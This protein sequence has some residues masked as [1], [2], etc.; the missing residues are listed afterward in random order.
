MDDYKRAHAAVAALDA[1]DFA[2]HALHFHVDT[3]SPRWASRDEQAL[4]RHLS[5]A[6]RLLGES[7][8]G[9]L[10]RDVER[11]GD[12]LGRRVAG[13]VLTELAAIN[14]AWAVFD[15]V[16][17]RAKRDLRL[18]PV[19]AL[20]EPP[21]E[22]TAT[23]QGISDELIQHIKRQPDVLY[24]LNPRRFEE[25]IAH[26]LDNYGWQVRMTPRTRDGGYDIFAISKDRSG[27]ECSWIIE[28]KK[29]AKDRKVG[30]ELARRLYF[31]KSELKVGMAMLATTSHFT[32]GVHEFKTSRWDFRLRDFTGILEW[33]NEYR[34]NANGRL[35]IKD[36]EVVL[37]RKP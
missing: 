20:P 24:D 33:I 4:L 29:F 8:S 1:A 30:I 26:L 28:C 3:D 12:M 5:E 27:E 6:V 36:G 22:I 35:C 19:L 10:G 32:K 13:D 9:V 37:L 34:P 11:I 14:A 21:P 25:L 23:I 31:V 17:E 15:R 16:A 2:F 7:D 18:L